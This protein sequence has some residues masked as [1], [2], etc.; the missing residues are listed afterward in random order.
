MEEK[1]KFRYDLLLISVLL[2]LSALTMIL[3]FSLR[4]EGRAVTVEIDGVKAGEYSLLEEGEYTL[5]DGGNILKIENGEAYL[6]YADCPDKTCVRTGRIKY[7]GQSI[8]CLPNK[9]VVIV[10]GDSQGGV[11]LVS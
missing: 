8:V 4:K 10:K 7:E 9:V 5:G 11:D 6:I 3:I 2:C 1:K